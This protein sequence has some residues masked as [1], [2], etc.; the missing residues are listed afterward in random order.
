MALKSRSI[1]QSP[2]TQ[3]TKFLLIFSLL[4]SLTTSIVVPIGRRSTTSLASSLLEDISN[5]LGTGLLEAAGGGGGGSGFSGIV[6]TWFA[7]RECTVTTPKV[8]MQ[9]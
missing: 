7:V 1:S 2:V 4:I 5:A 3:T 6:D 8:A 9:Q